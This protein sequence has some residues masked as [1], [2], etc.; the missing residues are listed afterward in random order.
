MTTLSPI[1]LGALMGGTAQLVMSRRSPLRPR[2]Y[3]AFVI[4]AVGG[5]WG[6]W[7]VSQMLPTPSIL[8]VALGAFVGLVVFNHFLIL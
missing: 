5:G 2:S 4:G 1:T 7:T 8:P 6:G 3:D